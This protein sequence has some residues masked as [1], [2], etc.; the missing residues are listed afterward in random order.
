M[1]TAYE[2]A[3]DGTR[4][5][6]DVAADSTIRVRAAAAGVGAAVDLSVVGAQR[7]ASMLGSAVT[8]AIQRGLPGGTGDD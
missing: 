2:Y 5:A 8:A 6:V 7:L 1:S 3:D 4:L